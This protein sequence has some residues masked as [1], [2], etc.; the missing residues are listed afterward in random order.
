MGTRQKAGSKAVYKEQKFVGERALFGA[1]GIEI[2]GCI[3][4]EGESPL[5]HASDLRINDCVFDWKYPL[6]YTRNVRL[7]N[8][9]LHESARS[10]LWYVQ[11][12]TARNCTI[13]AP[14]TFRR[15]TEITL[16]KVDLPNAQET[17]WNCTDIT[18]TDV[19]VRGDYFAMNTAG[20]RAQ[21]LSITGNYAFDGASNIEIDGAQIHSKDAFWNT[22]DV[23]V[24]NATI[25]GEYLGWN[26]H[27]LTF[28]NCTITSEQ[29]LCYIEGLTLRN[30][31]LI[32]TT[33]AFEYSDVD[34]E[35]TTP[36]TSVINPRGGT[37]TA[38]Q[39][40]DLILDPDRIDPAATT[41]VADVER[42]HD[43]SAVFEA[44]E[45]N[46]DQVNGATS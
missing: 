39:I 34:V 4:A 20:I 1:R 14:K 36:I 32:D 45:L 30:C 37:I 5:K 2:S 46:D 27:N 35:A 22:H 7:E 12:L 25:E 23:T 26:S 38:P 29:G 28:E 41:V 13:Q 18:L 16:E 40:G 43:C 19:N 15:A 21:N 3:F 33:L 44:G 9:I 11:G 10:G 8:T 24:R 17:F 42:A 6:W 31:R